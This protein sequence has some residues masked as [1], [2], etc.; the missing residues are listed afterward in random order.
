MKWTEFSGELWDRL[1]RIKE[2][3]SAHLWAVSRYKAL[4]WWNEDL[5]KELYAVTAKRNM[6]RDRS[7]ARDVD[8]EG[9]EA[10]RDEARRLA[11]EWRDMFITNVSEYPPKMPVYRLPWEVGDENTGEG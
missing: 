10:Q 5:R 2:N 9:M 8:R 11:E 4:Q 1:T 7:I 3:Q 6:Y